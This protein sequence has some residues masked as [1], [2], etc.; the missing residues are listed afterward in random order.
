[1]IAL[2]SLFGQLVVIN[3]YLKQKKKKN[4]VKLDLVPLSLSMEELCLDI[5]KKCL[6]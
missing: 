1:M 4:N 3:F 6:K 2:H 5:K